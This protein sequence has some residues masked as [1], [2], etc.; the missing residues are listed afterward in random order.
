MDPFTAVTTG[1]DAVNK[2][3]DAMEALKKLRGWLVKQPR[4]A[5]AELASVVGEITK[6]GPAV[7]RSVDRLFKVVDNAQPHL[8][9]LAAVGDGS[10]QREIAEIRPHCHEIDE[11]ADRYLSQWLGGTWADPEA[12][13]LKAFL[14]AASEADADYFREIEALAQAVADTATTAFHLAAT[15][16]RQ[17]A[18]GLLAKVAPP[19]FEARRRAM[20]LSA[21]LD[22]LQEEFRRMALGM[23][24]A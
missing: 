21:D 11:I 17:Q 20:R 15:G 2:L 5:A 22:D 16:H 3:A 7:A 8:Q 9:D 1:V 24:A 4:E 10:L 18:L 23:P 13:E 12:R 14:E 6:A 19:L